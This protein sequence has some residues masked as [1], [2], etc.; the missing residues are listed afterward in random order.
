MISSEAL[1]I[2]Y[3]LS[4]AITWGAGDFGGGFASK[5]SNV[6][7]VIFFSQIVGATLLVILAIGFSEKIPSLNHLFIGGLAGISGLLGLIALYK[8]LARGPMGIV[9]PTSSVVTAA[10]PTIFAMFAEGL[11]KTTQMFGFGIAILSVCFLSY[12][13]NGRRIQAHELYLPIGSGLGF[14][15]FFI[16]IGSVSSDAILW[17]L[18]AARVASISLMTAIVITRRQAIAPSMDQLP[19]IALVGIFDA[20]GNAFFALATESGRLDIS[21]VLASL[22]PAATVFLARFFLKE[23]LSFQQGIGLVAAVSA[24]VLIGI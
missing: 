1:A 19:L 2:T 12:A 18:V 8:G 13:G 6:L 5:R 7:T 4:S 24:L 3:G 14:G 11:P 15:L 17:P 16:L 21:A 10:I 9:A 20:G 22:G 23:R